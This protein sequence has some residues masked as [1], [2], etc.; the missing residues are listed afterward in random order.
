MA[1]GNPLGPARKPEP[2]PQSTYQRKGSSLREGNVPV[3]PPPRQ[4]SLLRLMVP[5]FLLGAL[6]AAL[7]AAWETGHLQQ[8]LGMD[9]AEEETGQP[10][11]TDPPEQTDTSQTWVYSGRAVYGVIRPFLDADATPQVLLVP[12][13]PRSIRAQL[14][15]QAVLAAQLTSAYRREREPSDRVDWTTYLPARPEEGLQSMSSVVYQKYADMLAKLD[16][17]AGDD[18][19]DQIKA[20]IQDDRRTFERAIEENPSPDPAL[21]ITERLNLRF[22]S[23]LE[24]RLG[25]MR[26]RARVESSGEGP[27]LRTAQQ[28]WDVYRNKVMPGL[29]E[30]VDTH[31]SAQAPLQNAGRFFLEGPGGEPLVELT[32]RDGSRVF[33]IDAEEADQTDVLAVLGLHQ[34]ERTRLDSE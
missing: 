6:A 32:L 8:W 33:L 34:V 30:W 1:E 2:T 20:T 21:V 3:S 5:L 4:P 27:D 7:Y 18:A 12:S 24:R 14:E 22:L 17:R 10:T 26:R 25:Q 11:A 28:A 19:F 16:A 23:A 15:R 29:T 31:R 13:P 9:Q